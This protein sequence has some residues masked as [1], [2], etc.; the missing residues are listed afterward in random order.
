MRM[1]TLKKKLEDLPDSLQVVKVFIEV[2]NK[3]GENQTIEFVICNN[4]L[5]TT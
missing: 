5:K 3:H 2:V 1:K 4:D